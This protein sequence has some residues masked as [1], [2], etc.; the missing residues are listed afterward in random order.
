LDS[1]FL[2]LLLLLL[3]EEV[4]HFLWN[5]KAHALPLEDCILKANLLHENEVE[6]VKVEVVLLLLMLR[7]EGGEDQRNVWLFPD[8]LVVVSCELSCCFLL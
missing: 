4:V 3:L 1:R 6:L 8:V 7:V 2:L 5:G